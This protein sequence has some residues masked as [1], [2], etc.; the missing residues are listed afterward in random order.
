MPASS[1]HGDAVTLYEVTA[2]GFGQSWPYNIPNPLRLPVWADTKGNGTYDQKCQLPFSY[3]GI[4]YKGCITR[5]NDRPWCY[6]KT[7]SKGAGIA[8]EWGNCAPSGAT[9]PTGRVGVVA[10]NVTEMTT[11]DRHLIN[12]SGS[13]YGKIDS[14]GPSG[15]SRW[16]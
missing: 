8:G 13:N 15:K 6:T 10:S 2:S 3:G 5:D 7:D 1:E 9:I 11:D 14:I 4:E 16:P 12:K